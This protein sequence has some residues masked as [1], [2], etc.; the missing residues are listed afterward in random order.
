[1][2]KTVAEKMGVREDMRAILINAPESSV[3]SIQLP[4][5]TIEAK[6]DGQFDHIHLFVITQKDM[7]KEFSNW[8]NI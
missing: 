6:L 5:I 7:H 8:R 1:M 3:V 4:P 2:P